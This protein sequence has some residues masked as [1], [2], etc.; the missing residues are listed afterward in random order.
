MPQHEDLYS[1]SK[2]VNLSQY[3]LTL[4]SQ[5]VQSLGKTSTQAPCHSNESV[6]SV[7]RCLTRILVHSFNWVLV[8]KSTDINVLL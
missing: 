3:M 2:G 1:E 5:F 6:L 7:F 4:K 8:S